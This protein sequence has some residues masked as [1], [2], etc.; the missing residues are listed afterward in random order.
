MLGEVIDAATG[1]DHAVV[2]ARGG[3]RAARHGRVSA[4]LPESEYGRALDVREPGLAGSGVA[5]FNSAEWRRRATAAGG[6]FA[7]ADGYGAVRA[8]CCSNGGAPLMAAETF[9]EMTAV[10][11]PGMPGGIESFQ[12]WD[13]ADWSLGCEVRGHKD[14]ALDRDAHVAGDAVAFRRLG[15]AVL[16]R[17]GGGRGTRLPRQSQHLLGLDHAPRRVA[18]PV[19]RRDRPSGVRS[20][21]PRRLGALSPLRVGRFASARSIRA[22][23]GCTVPPADWCSTT[24]PRPPRP[25]S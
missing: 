23:S 10:A 11:Y 25:P 22:R 3:V 12:T 9:A 16:R 1:I 7:T 21:R 24:I 4:A 13:D 6:A 14:A 8:A 17:S 15:H 2:R 19:R 5:L 20:E 18:R